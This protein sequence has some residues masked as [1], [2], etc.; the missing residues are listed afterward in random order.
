MDYMEINV[1][2]FW[3]KEKR[4]LRLNMRYRPARSP[5]SVQFP[6]RAEA[7]RRSGAAHTAQPGSG[8]RSCSVGQRSE[9]GPGGTGAARAAAAR[10]WRLAGVLAPPS[11]SVV[12]RQ[13]PRQRRA[14]TPEGGEAAPAVPP[15]ERS[16]ADAHRRARAR[17]G[18]AGSAPRVEVRLYLLKTAS[19]AAQ[20]PGGSV[21]EWS[22]AL[23]LGSSHFDGVGSN[24][25]AAKK[26]CLPSAA[27]PFRS[28][29]PPGGARGFRA[30]P[31][32]APCSAARSA[33]HRRPLASEC[34]RGGGE[35]RSPR[36]LPCPHRPPVTAVRVPRLRP[37]SCPPIPVLRSRLF[38][39]S[40]P[41]EGKAV[42]GSA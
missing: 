24:P 35:R 17:I 27:A 38:P 39:P 30:S 37:A 15:A 10:C 5:L 19:Q 2:S 34:R 42:C 11:G 41:G 28:R 25:T 40:I 21:A 33:A 12:P 7:Q 6:A 9:V 16:G 1:N 22:K 8:A 23:D 29:Q 3:V 31:R 4:V 14:A 32:G 26:F 13:R 36:V 18:G 20:P